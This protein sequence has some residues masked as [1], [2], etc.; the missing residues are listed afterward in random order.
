MSIFTKFKNRNEVWSA[1][2]FP[3]KDGATICD[4]RLKRKNGLG[5]F[6]PVKCNGAAIGIIA[7]V[8]QIPALIDLMAEVFE[9]AK[10]RLPVI[11]RTGGAQ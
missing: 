1:E 9:A 5:N 2:I 3:G 10:E 4:L 8:D 6:V 11:D 7:N